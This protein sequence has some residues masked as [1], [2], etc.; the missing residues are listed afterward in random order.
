MEK[1]KAA[2]AIAGVL[3]Y[4]KE[5]K[6]APAPLLRREAPGAAG[7]WALSGRQAAMQLRGLLQMRAFGRLGMK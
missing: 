3:Q 7:P 5:E 4:I 6:E 1:K 2:A